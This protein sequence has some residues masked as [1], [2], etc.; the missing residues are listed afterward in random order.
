MELWQLGQL[1]IC[2]KET[3]SSK[4]RM[5]ER[6]W[7][8]GLRSPLCLRD[9]REILSPAPQIAK[10]P[11]HSA[12]GGFHTRWL[13]PLFH[14]TFESTLCHCATVSNGLSA[15][16]NIWGMSSQ[17]HPQASFAMRPSHAH[18]WPNTKGFAIMLP[19]LTLDTWN[20]CAELLSC[21]TKG[22]ELLPMHLPALL[23]PL[24]C[25]EVHP[26]HDPT[27]RIGSLEHV[28][29][30]CCARVLTHVEHEDTEHHQGNSG[31][32]AA[33]AANTA[34]TLTMTMTM[35]MMVAV[36]IGRGG[37]VEWVTACLITADIPSEYAKQTILLYYISTQKKMWWSMMVVKYQ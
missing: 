27:S 35:M 15:N 22:L 11:P 28:A 9:L 26:I 18:T 24:K 32:G 19:K 14:Q 6:T 5:V 34:A 25:F 10:P 21:S 33:K 16:T 13:A 29:S 31:A 36:M 2:R 3:G 23:Q 8:N 37:G 1:H 20:A 30:T 12:G 7:L 17:N 4:N